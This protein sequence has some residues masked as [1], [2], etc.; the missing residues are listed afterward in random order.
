MSKRRI[1]VP[2]PLGGNGNPG[3]RL[4]SKGTTF[5]KEPTLAKEKDSKDPKDPKDPKKK[6]VSSTFGNP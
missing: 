2:F 1:G 5:V 3:P 6:K 4:L